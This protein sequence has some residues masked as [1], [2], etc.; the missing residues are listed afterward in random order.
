MGALNVLSEDLVM[1]NRVQEA[2]R[3][4]EEALRLNARD[5][6]ILCTAGDIHNRVNRPDL[7]EREFRTAL[8]QNPQNFAAYA[9]LANLYWAQR[10]APEFQWAMQRMMQINPQMAQQV[11]QYFQMQGVAQAAP[12]YGQAPQFR[13]PAIG[14]G[15]GQPWGQGGQ[16]GEQSHWL[17]TLSK[18]FNS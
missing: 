13:P 7:A 9:Q 17:S 6:R 4:I 12:G 8:E 2:Q 5:T 16:G 11:K 15:P 10:R 3:E 14:P 1:L 18:L